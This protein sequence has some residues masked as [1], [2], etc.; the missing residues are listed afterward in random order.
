MSYKLGVDVGGTFTDVCVFNQE[1]R[2]VMIHK[3]PSTPNDPSEAIGNGINQILAAHGISPGE[4]IYLAHGTTVATNACLERKGCKTGLITTKGF[5]DLIELARQK[6]SSLYDTQIEKPI[7][8]IYKNM[9]RE[10][11]ERI[12]SDGSIV[13]PIDTAEVERCVLELKESGAESYAVCFLHAYV[14]PEHEEIVEEIIQR[15]HPGAY[16]SLSSKVLPEFRE[17]ERMSTTALNSYIGPIVGKYTDLFKE[18]IRLLGADIIPYINQSNGGLMSIET[19]FRNP[20]RTALSGP[21]AGVSGANHVAKSAGIANYITFDMGGTSTDVCL[22]QNNTPP[23]ATSKDIAEFPVKVPMV[24]VNAVGAG[25]GSIAHIDNGGMLKVG[26]ESAGALPGPVAYCRGGTLPTVTD[27]NVVLH[28]LNPRYI[29]GGKMKIDE[30]GARNAIQKH[31]A[32]PLGLDTLAAA[33][34]IIEIVNAN[35]ARAVRTVSVER[36][37]DPRDFVMIAFGGAGALHAVAVADSLGIHRVLIPATPGILCAVGLLSSDIRTDYVRTHITDLNDDCCETLNQLY[38]QMEQEANEWLDTEHV[39]EKDKVLKRYA[40]V[41]YYGQNFELS[42]EV[43][44]GSFHPGV[45]KSIRDSFHREHK[46]EYGYCRENG[47]VQIVNYRLV[48]FG[49]VTAI[50]FRELE[51]GG[52]DASH[53]VTEERDVFFEENNGYVPTKIYARSKLLAGNI[54]PGPAIVEQLDSTIV[55]PPNYSGFVDKQQNL[56]IS[57]QE[58]P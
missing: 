39:E 8:I 57:K 23:I 10:V 20:I 53:A 47:L 56:M 21:A 2:E 44:D 52:T 48:A 46:R 15:V 24:D 11:P 35:M 7:P 37:Y 18:R 13:T 19:T 49:K 58:Q 38:Q 54:V 51:E 9:R 45:I 33:R 36:G 25:G 16:V 14:N 28:R 22:V 27:A 12:A 5:R 3:L 6:R 50:S 4:L 41:R 34:G 17:Y 1:S 31:I 40:D 30:E 42:V 55:I 26:P 43:P 32:E 29:L